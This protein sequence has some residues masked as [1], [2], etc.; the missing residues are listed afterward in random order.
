MTSL[1]GVKLCPADC[2]DLAISLFMLRTEV[3]HGIASCVTYVD[4]NSV[5]IKSK[6]AKGVVTADAILFVPVKK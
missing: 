4:G 3:F 1:R 5:T 2:Y 6:R